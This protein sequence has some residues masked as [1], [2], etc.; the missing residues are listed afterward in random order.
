MSGGRRHRM[1]CAAFGVA[2]SACIATPASAAT[3]R[4]AGPLDAYTLD[5][6]AVSNTFIFAILSNVYEPLVRRG[7][8]LSLE[9]ALATSWKQVDD[10][11]WRFD[12]RKGVQFQD[13]G[14]FTASDVVFSFERAKAGGVR[15]NLATLDSVKAIDDDTVEIRTKDI[16]PI[17]PTEITN[18]YIMERAWAEK[19]GALLPG[20]ADNKTETYANRATNGT[21]PYR[22]VLRDPG[23]K[24]EFERNLGW[25]DKPQGN[26]DKA[27]FFVIP[28]ASSR[29]S[30][31]ISGEVDMI[32]SLP[33][34][35]TPRV[36]AT[37]GLRVQA[38]PDLRL[39]YL[40]P[41]IARDELQYSDVKGKNPFQDKRVRQAMQLVI[42]VE[43]IKSKVMR[44]YSIPTGTP[45]AKEVNGYTPELG[46]PVSPDLEKAKAL[47]SEA[48]Y[49]NGFKVTLDCTN[50]RF[51][52][53]EATCVAITGFLS[54]IGIKVETRAQTTGKWA[55]QINP[56]GYNTSLVL[57]GYS[58]F[59]YDA[60]IF[61][62]SIVATRDQQSGR[63]TFNIGGYSDPKVDQ[64]IAKIQ[65]DTNPEERRALIGQ[66]LS[67]VKESAAY[68][69]IHQLEILWGV[70]ENVSVVQPADLSFP[71]R[72]FSVK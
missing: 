42:D 12:L 57:V 31:L 62:S 33:P 15:T 63:G 13:G 69:P 19:N 10:K 70:K 3:F 9:P 35:D 18:W 61:L 65:S 47:M 59:T 52:N 71:L 53:D 26:I 27:T 55:Q 72:L 8:D 22:I 17:V 21:G 28:N 43:A 37:K 60:H 34:Q 67:L 5:P 24:I 25:W 50:D 49:P 2:L 40:Q 64:L 1:F 44:G 54:R 11:T 66:A 36:E 41:D 23:L 29:V 32:D 51:M 20:S 45:I 48:G 16:D 4:F 7:A 46:K 14:A 39:I 6:H 38:G 68:I 58:P 56:P 30:A